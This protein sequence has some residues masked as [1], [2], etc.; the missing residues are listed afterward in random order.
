MFDNFI[1][2]RMEYLYPSPTPSLQWRGGVVNRK[3]DDGK[4]V[5]V[6]M[7]TAGEVASWE[8]GADKGFIA[9]PVVVVKVAGTNKYH[10]SFP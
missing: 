9:I 4:D 8:L 6:D 5:T 2:S 1:L 7:F 3:E 10:L